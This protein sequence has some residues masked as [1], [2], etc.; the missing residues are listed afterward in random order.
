MLL[1][2]YA[3]IERASVTCSSLRVIEAISAQVFS[4]PNFTIIS[5]YAAKESVEFCLS[6]LFTLISSLYSADQTFLRFKPLS[7]ENLQSCSAKSFVK[8][9]EFLLAFSE[10][11]DL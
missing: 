11:K 4:S 9:K 2:L 8:S 1:D 6:A 5:F 7:I 10:I 3:D